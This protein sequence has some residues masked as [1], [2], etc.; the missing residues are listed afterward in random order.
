MRCN[1]LSMSARGGPPVHPHRP[2][3]AER[4]ADG[5]FVL[6]VSSGTLRI[7]DAAALRR[8]LR[9]LSEAFEFVHFGDNPRARARVS[10]WAAAAVALQERLDP[11]VHVTCRDRN[12]LALEAD[13]I[14]GHLLGVR[15]FLCLRGDEIEIS[16]QPA[17]RAVRDLDVI[18]LLRLAH[19]VAGADACLLAACDPNAGDDARLF[20]RLAEKVRAGASLLET[21]PVFEVER[22]AVWLRRL[23]EAGIAIPL[24][25]DVFLL[26]GPEQAAFLRRIPSIHVPDEFESRLGSRGRDPVSATV[27]TVQSLRALP[28]VAGCHLM[29]LG[30]DTDAI[31]EVAARAGSARTTTAPPLL[32][33]ARGR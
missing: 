19:K 15:N 21:Q 16:D 26:T 22:F 30:S 23:R 2:T 17:A 25:V 1:R 33:P 12:R 24:L 8:A 32:K 9:E 28:G 14:G 5:H 10:P 4:C 6:T 27:E 20:A 29:S 18:D 13:I 7:A 11:V 3:L 31:L